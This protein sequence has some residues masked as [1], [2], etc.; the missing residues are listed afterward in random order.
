MPGACFTDFN[1]VGKNLYGLFCAFFPMKYISE[2]LVE[3]T[4]KSLISEKKDP[5]SVGEMLVF[6]GLW[7]LM[8]TVV[9]FSRRDFFSHRP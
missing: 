1:P 4:S 6:I 8:A 3:E 2:I 9:G 7:L 5:T